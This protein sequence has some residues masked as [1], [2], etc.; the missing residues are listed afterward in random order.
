M[1]ADATNVRIWTDSYDDGANFDPITALWTSAGALIDENDDNSS[2]NPATQTEWDSGFIV[3]FLS[4]GDYIFTVA[5]FDNFANGSTLAEGFEFDNATPIPITEWWVQAP[6]YY[7]VNFDGVDSVT[8]DN[9]VP[10]PATMLL[11]GFGL[12]GLAGFSR[13]KTA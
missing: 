3:G 4:A 8:P 1:N 7:N 11:F 10:E 9:P 13:K 5:A 12:L 6:G 2:V